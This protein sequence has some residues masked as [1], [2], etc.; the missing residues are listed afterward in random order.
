MFASRKST[1]G[2]GC[3]QVFAT[4]HNHSYVSPMPV[5]SHAHV[6]LTEY[7][8]NVGVP[9]HMQMDGAKELTEGH[10]KKNILEQQIKQTRSETDSQ[11]QNRAE[12][13]VRE[14]KKTC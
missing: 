3:A 11:F 12:G 2:N 14:M 6:A 5:K 4:E 8:E 9:R 1:R 10:W 13:L 7:Y